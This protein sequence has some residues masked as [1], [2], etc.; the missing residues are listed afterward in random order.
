LVA[1]LLSEAGP[2]R[3]IRSGTAATFKLARNAFSLAWQDYQPTCT[4][5]DFIAYRRRRASEAWKHAMW[6]ACAATDA[7][8]RWSIALL[9]RR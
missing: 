9:L 6:A 5:K 2:A 8:R 3:E 7:D 4:E 1:R